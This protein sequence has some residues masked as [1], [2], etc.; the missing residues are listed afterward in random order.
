MS[1]QPS[2]LLGI[3]SSYKFE[4]DPIRFGFTE[5]ETMALMAIGEGIARTTQWAGSCSK[6]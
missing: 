3:G 4:V 2:N 1:L 6:L 5:F